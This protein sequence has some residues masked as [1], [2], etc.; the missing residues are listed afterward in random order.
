[1]V[2]SETH[3][4]QF[5]NL[6]VYNFKNLKRYSRYTKCYKSMNWLSGVWS[7][8]HRSSIFL[9]KA[10]LY[11]PQF[12]RP[13]HLLPG[14][15]LPHSSPCSTPQRP[16]LPVHQLVSRPL[17]SLPLEPSS[18][19]CGVHSLALAS[20]CFLFR[21]FPDNLMQNEPP[22]SAPSPFFSS[23]ALFTLSDTHFTC[24]LTVTCVV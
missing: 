3:P 16:G 8:G 5:M 6:S 11:N 10:S 18:G 2:K 17:P 24:C 20:L 15:V 19:N 22:A 14:H 9:R 23:V 4:L 21:D 12:Y 13:C 7:S 1:M